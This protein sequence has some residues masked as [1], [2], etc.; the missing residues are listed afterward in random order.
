MKPSSRPRRSSRS[1]CRSSIRSPRT[2]SGG[3]RASPSGR[4]SPW[5]AALRRPLPAARPARARLLRPAR[6]PSVMRAAGA[7]RADARHLRLLLLLLLVQRAPLAR[8]PARRRCSRAGEPRLAVLRLLGERELDAALGRRRRRRPARAGLRAAADG[9]LHP[10]PAP[11]LAD[12]RY[13]RVDGAPLLLVYRRGPRSG[14]SHESSSVAR[15]RAPRARPD[16]HLAAVQSF[17]IDDPRTYGFDAA[18][19]FP[20]HTRAV[21]GRHRRGR[22]GSSRV[23]GP[24]R[25]LSRGDCAP[26][27][28]QP[29]R[30]PLVP[31]RHA[32]VGQHRPARPRRPHPDQLVA[33]AVRALAP[34]ADPADTR[35][36]ERRRRAARLRR[37]RG[38]S[39]PRERTSSPTSATVAP[40]SRRRATRCATA[41][42][43]SMP[44]GAGHGPLSAEDADAHLRR[45]L[46]P[47]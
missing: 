22:V 18:V 26:A 45:A 46:P 8:A 12:P 19:E 42:A 1:T 3:A 15:A 9:P 36:R 13:I 39:G 33:R 40:G 23:P 30:L 24:P 43:S 2:T 21:P 27:R 47:L 20:P 4:T 5:R 31:R 11:A 6:C 14:R 41:S 38:T 28:A 17:G 16:L 10:R 32:V 25:G 29:A 37:T 44:F 7:A 34:E 35:P